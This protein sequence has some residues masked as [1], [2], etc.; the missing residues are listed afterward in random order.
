[1]APEIQTMIDE[2][3]QKATELKVRGN[4]KKQIK[5]LLAEDDRG[6]VTAQTILFLMEEGKI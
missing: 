3:V 4:I 5:K 2:Q 1:M 6:V